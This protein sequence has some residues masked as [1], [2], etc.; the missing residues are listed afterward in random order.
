MDEA[1]DKIDW[2]ADRLGEGH[3]A[4]YYFGAVRAV[5]MAKPY[6]LLRGDSDEVQIAG[7][8]P[9]FVQRRLSP[10]VERP[11]EAADVVGNIVYRRL[12]DTYTDAVVGTQNR[13]QGRQAQTT[14][15]ELFRARGVVQPVLDD[16]ERR[17][18]ELR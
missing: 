17:V 7:E 11:A 12:V 6:K 15:L 10:V 14:M 5:P 1:N 9:E 4:S 18:D 13:E 16:V 8:D 2:V 3:P